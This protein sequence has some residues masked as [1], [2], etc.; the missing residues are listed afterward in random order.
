MLVCKQ[1]NLQL[2][3]LLCCTYKQALQRDSDLTTCDY[4]AYFPLT[5]LPKW[6]MNVEEVFMIFSWGAFS[7][8]LWTACGHQCPHPHSLCLYR[9]LLVANRKS[10]WFLQKQATE[11]RSHQ[12]VPSKTKPHFGNLFL[13]YKSWALETAPQNCLLTEEVSSSLQSFQGKACSGLEETALIPWE[14][15]GSNCFHS[16]PNPERH[17]CKNSE[18]LC[19]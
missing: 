18:L 6:Q 10:G 19:V 7:L 13:C 17:S 8:V 2:P 5:F 16:P 12:T 11:V 4:L 14:A 9:V 3:L 1:R 15:S